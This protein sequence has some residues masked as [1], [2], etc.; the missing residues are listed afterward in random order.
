MNLKLLVLSSLLFL[1]CCKDD[2][3]LNTNNGESVKGGIGLSMDKLKIA[4]PNSTTRGGIVF[5]E[6]DMATVGMYCS[7][8]GQADWD[9]TNPSHTF[10]R[11]E[12][13]E[14]VYNTA[15]GVWDWGTNGG[16]QQPRWAHSAMNDKFTFFAYSPYHTHNSNI[17]IGTNNGFPTI[18]YTVPTTCAD[19]ID[20]MLSQPCNNLNPPTDGNAPLKF[21]HSLSKVSFSINGNSKITLKEIT[22]EK[23]KSEGKIY[24]KPDGTYAWGDSAV[25][26]D[27]TVTA[28]TDIEGASPDEHDPTDIKPVTKE[29]GYLFMIPQTFEDSIEVKVKVDNDGTEEEYTLNIPKGTKWEAGEHYNYIIGLYTT[30]QLLDANCY[31]LHRSDNIANY[32]IPIDG[33]INEFWGNRGYYYEPDNTISRA[34][35]KAGKITAEV[36]W[37]DCVDISTLVFKID[38]VGYN[39]TR[40]TKAIGAD[41][42]TLGGDFTYLGT[43]IALNVALNNITE[44][45]IVVGIKKGGKIIWSWHLWITE[46]NPDKIAGEQ[47]GNIVA[48]QLVYPNTPN[49]PATADAVGRV[50][51]YIDRVV[52][53]P[54]NYY[55]NNAHNGAQDVWAGIYSDKFIMDRNIGARNIGTITAL[56]I[57]KSH[58]A[59][60]YQFGRPNPFPASSAKYGTG[61]GITKEVAQPNSTIAYKITNPLKL[62]NTAGVWGNYSALYTEDFNNAEYLWSDFK[63]LLSNTLNNVSDERQKSIF[64]PSPLGW[65]LCINGTWSD[66]IQNIQSGPTSPPNNTTVHY[67]Y[68]SINTTIIFE[69]TQ[70]APQSGMYY[71]NEVF[72]AYTNCYLSPGGELNFNGGATGYSWSASTGKNFGNTAVPYIDG[73]HL[74]YTGWTDGANPIPAKNVSHSSMRTY[75][76]PIRCVQE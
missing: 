50:H 32:K 72:Y 25:E 21:E 75:A 3:Y 36:I 62:I 64:D 46:Y 9:N 17:T 26:V 54:T 15:T 68:D 8:T 51:R 59:V 2:K 28:T 7:Y 65:R 76:F 6:E 1:V 70:G 35:V 13:D 55:Y 63:A 27:F 67:P 41:I 69:N 44:G 16:K 19:Q 24:Y 31:M 61:Y 66:F 12:N 57:N 60:Y 18:T 71:R 37:H 58:G 5:D 74:H 33:R 4:S 47:K 10:N 39:G 48:G 29:L 45:N 23:V 56:D 52:D 38:T 22:L 20:L 34:D 14:Y 53:N 73:H 49:P 43:K 11:L 30:E 42:N 40:T